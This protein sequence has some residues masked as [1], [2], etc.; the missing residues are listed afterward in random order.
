MQFLSQRF[1]SEKFEGQFQKYLKKFRIRFQLIQKVIL[2]PLL[3]YYTIE[4]VFSSSWIVVSLNVILGL[5]VMFSLK[6]QKKCIRIYEILIMIGI[7]LFNI[8]YATSQYLNVHPQRYQFI[9]GYFLAILSLTMI[10]MMDTIQKAFLLL[11]IYLIYIIMIPN[12]AEP[13]WQQ[14]IKFFLYI[15]LY[16]QQQRYQQQL[17]RL[18]YLQ[19]FKH[20]TIENTIRENLDMKYYVV[21]F[22][23]KK[24]SFLLKSD[25][26][27][28]ILNEEDQYAFQQFLRK[29]NIS[30]SSSDIERQTF[31]KIRSAKM[32]LEQF[33]FY[34]FTDRNKLQSLQSYENKYLDYQH[35]IYGFT[36][37]ESYIIKVIKCYDTDPCAIILITEQQ[38]Q[39][40][41]DKL[42][43]QNKATL[44]L[45]NYFSDIFTTQ[46]RVAL[47]ILNRIL[48]YKQKQK[49]IN[50]KNKE[51]QFLKYINS[52][53]YI[54]YNQFYNISDYF[55]A[56]S[57]FRRIQITKFNLIQVIQELFE[58]LKYYRKIDQIM[59]RTFMLITKIQEL[60]I[61]SDMKQ[62]S[63][64]FFNV[65]KFAMKYSD[66][67]QIDL[68]EGFD[69]S[70]PPQP[71]INV[72][73]LF[74]NL[75]GTKMEL[76]QFPIINPKTLQEIKTN[77][78]RPLELDM[79]IS[80]L[81]IRNLG[82]FDKMTIR[83]IGKQFYKI[84]FFIYKSMNQ[85]LHLIPINSFD[86][87][88]FIKRD[89][90]WQQL[91]HFANQSGVNCY[92]DSPEIKLD[93]LRCIT[94]PDTALRS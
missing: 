52:Q 72:Q 48:K 16:Y 62:I 21:N 59:T 46:I 60:N 39:Q 54:A 29:I 17:L 41:V 87:S 83:K 24:R 13:A 35:H 4:K 69:Q 61:K 65:T 67:I 23:E 64:L 77:D 68:D 27:N 5:I 28:Q 19:Y 81:I 11:F 50:S 42:K 32:N 8:F 58:K 70:Y 53:L 93:T 31:T 44:K 2:L 7:L 40:F 12:Q 9:D 14:I 86:P 1:V 38:K 20:L 25:D 26:Y 30:S 47:I 34:L 3:I 36:T 10:N 84:Q 49:N 51:I 6:Y 80:L 92:N 33:L 74:K 85:D 45:L 43:L 71:I 63:Q 78:K 15:V 22:I 90:D 88:L 37:E 66:E 91:N 89:D 73:I 57:E 82:P 94:I 79:S 56:N 18:T 55:Q 75:K 76:R